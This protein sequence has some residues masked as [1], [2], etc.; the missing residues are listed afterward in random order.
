MGIIVSATEEPIEDV[1][2]VEIL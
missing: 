2:L 1:A